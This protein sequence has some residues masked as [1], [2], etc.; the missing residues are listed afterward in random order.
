MKIIDLLNR[1][2]K[3]EEVPKK[4]KYGIYYWTY[5]QIGKDYKDNDGDWVFSCSNYDI[6]EI[7]N[8]TVEIPEEENKIEKINNAYY[9]EE[10]DMINQIFKNKINELIDEINKLKEDK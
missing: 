8:D 7:L 9:H 3:G 5:D 10:Q 6:I 4:I 1:I 2:A